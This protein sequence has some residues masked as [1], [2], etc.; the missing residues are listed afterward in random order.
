M[1]LLIRSFKVISLDPM[2]IE[3][4]E[5]LR[6]VTLCLAGTSALVCLDLKKVVALSTLSQLRVIIL[7]ISLYAPVLAFFHLITHALFKALL[8]LSVGSVIHSYGNVQDIRIVGGCWSTLPKRIRAIVIAVSSLSGL[9][10]LSGF[11]SKDLIV[12]LCYR[13]S[14]SLIE[15]VLV[16]VGIAITRVYSL[17][18]V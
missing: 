3:V 15:V 18:I 12:D 6:L 8:F 10:F 13:S 11:F 9:P 2:F 1:Y 5:V 16:G 7:R 4:L 17:R 14:I